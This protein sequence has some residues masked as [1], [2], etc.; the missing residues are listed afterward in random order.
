MIDVRPVGRDLLDACEE[1][2]EILDADP[3]EVEERIARVVRRTAAVERLKRKG[4]LA[5]K[6]MS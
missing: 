6:R 3:T 1:L 2:A 4:D 5:L